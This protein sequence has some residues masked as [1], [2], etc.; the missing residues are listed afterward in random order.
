[1]SLSLPLPRLQRF[2]LVEE[3]G[4]GQTGVIYRAEARVKVGN[5]RPGAVVAVKLLHSRLLASDAAR[6]TFLREARAGMKVSHPNL[7]RVHAVEEVHGL[8]GRQLYVVMELLFGRNLREWLAEEGL[9]SEPTLRT[10]GRQAAAGLRALHEAGLLHL[11]VKPE[12][13]MWDQDRAVL[14]DLGFVRPTLETPAGDEDSGFRGTPAYAAPEVLRGRRPT[15]AAD[16]FALGVTLYECATGVRPFGDERTHGLFEARRTAYVRKPST[17]QP[18]L[19]PFFDRLV[20]RL[21]AEDPADRFPSSAALEEALASG[22]DGA[23]W[24]AQGSTEPLLPV[25]HPNALPFVNRDAELHHLGALFSAVRRLRMP[26]IVAIHGGA[27]LGKSRLALEFAQRWRQTPQAPPF[28]YGRCLREGRR[29]SALAAVRDAVTRSLGL[30]PG[31]APHP[32]VEGR[33]RTALSHENAETLLGILR[34]RPYPREPRRRALLAWL[35]ALG[36]EGPLL[37][38]LDDVQAAASNLWSFLEELLESPDMPALVLLTHQEELSERAAAARRRLLRHP[39]AEALELRPLQREQMSEL[40]TRTFEAGGLSAEL[41]NGLLEGSGGSPGVL[42]DLLR[43]LSQRGDLEGSRGS[44]R[45]ARP[46]VVVPPTRDQ[47]QIVEREI[48][49]MRADRRSLLQWVSLLAPPISMRFLAEVSGHSE[50][51]IARLLAWLRKAGWLKVS[52]GRY[53]FALP[54]LRE[55][56]YRSLS[57]AEQ[58]RRHRRVFRA[59]Q[60]TALEIQGRDARLALHARR[61]ELP[62][63][64]IVH[65]LPLL[66]RR[67]RQSSWERAEEVM[68]ILR[69]CAR[70]IAEEEVHPALRARMLLAEARLRGHGGDHGEEAELLKQAGAIARETE[71]NDLRVRVYLGLAR[72]A[73]GLG[74]AGAA[75]LHLEKALA[76][77]GRREERSRAQA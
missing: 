63:E 31:Q 54:S 51:R 23:W 32:A 35:R 8:D 67:I 16:L 59:L 41:R 64:A 27:S 42:T 47:Q 53:R 36:M 13:L 29:G 43:Y 14:M 39:R 60:T 65:G 49:E 6:A 40:L 18:R 45:A 71:D 52:G 62:A 73:R 50:I 77:S 24:R 20:T 25:I 34:G 69:G 5:L 1:M 10:L 4:R 66:E 58:V 70:Q 3:I 56:A 44:L 21:L 28:L 46:R 22:E 33:V 17:I 57:E 30:V 76:L 26:H 19:S 15:E 12:N 2:R 37:L 9:A 68:D 7:V 75:R 61:G 55:A 72:H 48:R 74:F 11:D 38:L